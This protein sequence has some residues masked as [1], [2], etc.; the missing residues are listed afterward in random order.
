MWPR[1][2]FSAFL[3][4]SSIVLIY[5][6]TSAQIDVNAFGPASQGQPEVWRLDH[7]GTVRFGYLVGRGPHHGKFNPCNTAEFINFDPHELKPVPLRCQGSASEGP[8]H[9]RPVVNLPDVLDSKAFQPAVVGEARVGSAA[10]WSI[11]VPKLKTI[12]VSDPN[13]TAKLFL[14]VRTDS[15]A[16]VESLGASKTFSELILK[17]R[18]HS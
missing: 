6:K 11:D 7:N 12:L 1:S 16:N 18:N 17:E 10:L 15:K 14:Y 9:L 2:V 5:T 8:G 13:L 3:A 4:L